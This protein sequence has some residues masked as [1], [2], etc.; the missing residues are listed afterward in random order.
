MKNA[1]NALL[2]IAVAVVGLA[3]PSA[4]AVELHGYLRSG[5]GG[6]NLGGNQV[7][8]AD[9]GMAYKF[10]L[11]NECENYAE[12]EFRDTLYKDKSGV[13]FNYVGMLAYVTPAQQDAESLKAPNNDIML[14]QNWIGATFPQLGNAMFW[15][16]KRYYHRNDVHIIDFFYWDP[17][18]PG[19]GVDDI[20]LGVGKIAL[21]VFQTRFDE[22]RATIWRP[23]LRW[24]GIPVSKN[25]TIELGADLFITW[26]QNAV[27]PPNVQKVSPWLTIQHTQSNFL[28]GFNKIAFQ[29]ATGT[30]AP[31]SS[32]PN[33]ANT[34]SSKQW[35]VV[36]QMVFQPSPELSGMLSFTY[37]DTTAIYGKTDLF[38]S[39]KS[40]G[41]G[42]RPT[43]HF[44]DFF[45]LA[46]DVGYTQV[47]PKNGTDT[48]DMNLFKVT[49]APTLVPPAGPGGAFFTRPE[50][51]LFVTYATW[52]KAAQFA[53]GH[54]NTAGVPDAGI[55]GQ[56]TCPATGA[57]N[58][59]FRCDTSGVTFGAQVETWW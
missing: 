55:V 9:P 44:S 16:G 27:R 47:K 51:R 22:A 49:V 31:M 2:A 45:K 19:A 37:Q 36:E 59:V 23:D 26:D 30:A 34:D 3:A 6:N 7:C 12:L 28:G 52:N 35:R 25:G 20:D 17:S 4:S 21:A 11:G 8:F 41:V 18:G 58:S 54:T 38:N 15:I 13:T 53:Q 48:S 56:G 39:S 40:W 33:A 46:V 57:S 10:R 50:L 1:R 5:I 29:W 32:Y 24:Y 42:G 43:Y 14:R